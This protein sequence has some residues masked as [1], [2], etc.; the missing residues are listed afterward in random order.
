MYVMLPLLLANEVAL[1]TPPVSGILLLHN[2]NKVYSIL[3]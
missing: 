1:L 2:A 3:H